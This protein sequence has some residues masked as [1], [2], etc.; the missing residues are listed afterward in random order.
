MGREGK[1]GKEERRE[2][3][4]REGGA[5]GRAPKAYAWGLQGD[6]PAPTICHD[7]CMYSSPRKSPLLIT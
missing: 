2:G 6:N 3:E 5:E 1:K 7:N 4:Q